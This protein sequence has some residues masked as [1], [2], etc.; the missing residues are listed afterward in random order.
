MRGRL[1]TSL[2]ALAFV[3]GLS[4]C[5]DDEASTP[6][7]VA[8][9]SPTPAPTPAPTPSALTPA[10]GEAAA[11]TD[12]R[13]SIAFDAPPVLGTT[14]SIR[15]YRADGLLVDT[16]RLDGSPVDVGNETQTVF[17]RPNTEVDRIGANV[18]G[19]TQ[20]RHVYYRPVTVAG[21]VATVRLH[22]NV[23]EPLTGYYVQVDA[24][25][26]TGSVRGAAFAGVSGTGWAFRTKAMPTADQ[27]TVDDDGSADF[28]T[29]QGALDYVM[30][31]GCTT[32]AR[33]AADKRVTVRRGTYDGLLFLRNVNRLTIVGEDRAGSVVRATNFD[34]FNPG[35]G[36]SRADAAATLSTIGSR[37]PG[38]TR[39]ALG[40]GRAVMLVENADELRLENLTLRNA[41]VKEAGIN[42]QA[43]ALYFNSASLTGARLTARSVDFLS[44][45]DTVQAKG[46]VWIYDSLIA[47]DVDFVWGSPFAFLIEASELRTVA[48]TVS[49][50]SGGYI[51]QSRAAKGYPGFVVLNS[52][53]TAEAGVPAGATWLAR[54][55][56]QGPAQGYCTAPAVVGGPFT[57][58]QLFCD[59]VA[60]LSTRMGAHVSPLGWFD[61]PLPNL[62]PTAAEGWREQGSLDAEGRPL[63]LAARRT[64]IA[65]ATADLGGLSTRAQVFARWNDG[66]GWTP[67]P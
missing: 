46:W 40:G 13:L 1:C 53:L 5:G 32:C 26:L 42:N 19:L 17:A 43:E 52:R 66:A 8:T 18:P 41:H 24:G 54:S 20:Y 7:P 22:D 47:G 23:L 39:R 35:T 21:N 11:Y 57:N 16:I 37:Q 60:F 61:N 44:T 14:G 49:P 45:Q 62:A 2:A 6:P 65:S 63:S 30:G 33:A 29:V 56:G 48:D 51:F 10:N 4:G 38:A 28:R 31:M 3:L 9:P 55:G 64:G 15:V 12:T 58:P 25:V 34:A 27:V 50:Q 67:T 36:G 59:N